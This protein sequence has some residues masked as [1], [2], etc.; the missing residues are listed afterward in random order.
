M[1]R[2]G[3]STG[4]AST[5]GG[6]PRAICRPCSCGAPSTTRWGEEKFGMYNHVS[7]E[8]AF[9]SSE[10]L[11]AA[12]AGLLRD[13]DSIPPFT[14]QLKDTGTY[15]AIVAKPLG[16]PDPTL[17]KPALALYLHTSTGDR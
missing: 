15:P 9:L 2:I 5:S 12:L 11:G 8:Y 14:A 13:P 1:P 7:R 6:R 10:R 17:L 16:P 3:C 4:S